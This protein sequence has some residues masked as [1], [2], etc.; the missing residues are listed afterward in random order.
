M[1]KIVI[2]FPKAEV[3]AGIKKILAQS[4]YPVAAVC[5]SGA[6]TLQAVNDLE[7]GI[8]ICGYRFSDML[9]S[10]IYE[11]L[12]SGFQM[13]LVASAMAVMEKEEE[14]LV[15]LSMPLKVHDLLHTVEM[16]DYRVT[17]RRKKL[18]NRPK[19]RTPEELQLIQKAKELLMER[20]RLTEEEAHQYIQ[21]RSMEN[22]TGLVEIAQMIISL[23][24]DG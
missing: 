12:P 21:R 23:M 18:K 8:L 16:M 9:Y 15:C 5:T 20:N 3:A 19:E 10:E 14:H 22:G 4:G 1:N 11:Y 2:A 6:K 13:L 17:R 7:D 24:G